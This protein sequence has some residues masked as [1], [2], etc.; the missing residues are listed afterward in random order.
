MASRKLGLCPFSIDFCRDR[1]HVSLSLKF[2]LPSM[3][4]NRRGRFREHSKPS[5]SARM[6]F[7][8]S[9]TANYRYR[10]TVSNCCNCST[11][12]GHRHTLE[13]Y[14]RSSG[15]ITAIRPIMISLTRRVCLIYGP[16]QS[17]KFGWDGCCSGLNPDES[18]ANSEGGVRAI[19]RATAREICR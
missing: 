16:G 7:L 3:T 5:Y 14:I 2:T 13:I 18:I 10:L 1:S 4:L 11:E 9:E 6:S 8:P 17:R 15:S 19:A 12:P